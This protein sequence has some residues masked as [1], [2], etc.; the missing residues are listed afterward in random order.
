MRKSID[1][2]E[3]LLTRLYKLKKEEYSTFT[4]GQMIVILL[5]EKLGEMGE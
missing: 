1:I 5:T 3:N 2:P 4:L